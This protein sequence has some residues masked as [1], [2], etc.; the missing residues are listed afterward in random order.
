MAGMKMR[1]M[2]GLALLAYAGPATA[3]PVGRW[4]SG[5]G[6]GVTEYGFK[7]DDR[8][9]IYIA[10]DPYGQTSVSVTIN[11]RSPRPRSIVQFKVNGQTLSWMASRDG[12]LP[13]GSHVDSS[14]YYALIEEARNGS[15]V[16]IIQFDALRTSFPLKGS[17]RALPAN[18]CPSDFGK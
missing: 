1:W 4:W 7:R 18:P 12:T 5:W 11:G 17:A 16:M 10:C 13:T 15:G 8:N 14:N 3:E 9:N 6:M 2:L